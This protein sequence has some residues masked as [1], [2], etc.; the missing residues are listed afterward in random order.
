VAGRWPCDAPARKAGAAKPE[1]SWSSTGQADG[2]FATSAQI[3][4]ERIR[5]RERNIARACSK[6]ASSTRRN[7][8][9]PTGAPRCQLG[10][11]FRLRPQVLCRS[12]PQ[13]GV[14][15]T[16]R[17]RIV[18]PATRARLIF[19]QVS[20]FRFQRNKSHLP[21]VRRVGRIG[22]CLRTTTGRN[23]EIRWSATEF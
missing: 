14:A 12:R 6:I 4:R 9:A 10:S 21:R 1:I 5:Y 2:G 8:F 7:G 16:N 19:V 17:R 3:A 23:V 13:P 11:G 22:P 20:N 18:P 15:T